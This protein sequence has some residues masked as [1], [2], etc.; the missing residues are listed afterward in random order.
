MMKAIN[1]S[2]KATKAAY[3]PL[4][5]AQMSFYKTFES[6]VRKSELVVEKDSAL[7]GTTL[8]YYYEGY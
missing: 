7:H 3:P 1:K 8:Y 4:K 6:L 2:R 5:I